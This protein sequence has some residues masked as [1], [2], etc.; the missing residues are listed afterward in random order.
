MKP[1]WER[2]K[3]KAW[4]EIVGQD[5]ALR[6]L[7]NIRKSCGSL[8]GQVYWI[9]GKSGTGKGCAASL[10]AS[11][12]AG[13]NVTVIP[14][15]TGVNAELLEPIEAEAERAKRLRPLFKL[16]HRAFIVSEAH[17]IRAAI[18][19]R[20]N[21][22]LEL[23]YVM[24]HYT[25]IFTT[26]VDGDSLFDEKMDSAPF[27]SRAHEITLSQRNLAE[28]FAEHVRQI[29]QSIQMDGQP[30]ERY[31]RLARDCGLNMRKMLQ[32]VSEGCMLDGGAE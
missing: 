19:R 24:E 16:E 15:G 21:G 25:W 1:L 12:V 32:R 14:D 27:C 23:P 10:I 9:T 30:I 31:I 6:T 5:K 20:L 22:V 17:G 3:P 8:A 29:A 28:P 7:D 11:E 13:E 26:T 18:V 2:H 4:S